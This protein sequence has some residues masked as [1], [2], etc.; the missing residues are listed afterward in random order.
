MLLDGDGVLLGLLEGDGV[1][2]GDGI[3]VRFID[4]TRP[5]PVNA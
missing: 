5:P 3:S 4:M 1:G 2:D